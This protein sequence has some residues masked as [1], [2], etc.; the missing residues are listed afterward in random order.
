M[1]TMKLSDK[2]E[3]LDLLHELET[4][5]YR[6]RQILSGRL[7]LI[8]LRPVGGGPPWPSH[9]DTF[10]MLW[11]YLKA[12]LP[13][14]RSKVLDMGEY[15]NGIYLATEIVP[16]FQSLDQWLQSQTASFE[17][18]TV[19]VRA[20]ETIRAATPSPE[21]TR[22][23]PVKSTP[24]AQANEYGGTVVRPAPPVGAGQPALQEQAAKRVMPETASQKMEVTQIPPAL[25]EAL[26]Q[27][28]DNWLAQKRPAA[29]PVAS[30]EGL[31]GESTMIFRRPE[32]PPAISRS[33]E[34]PRQPATAAP[35]SGES[36]MLLNPSLLSPAAAQQVKQPSGIESAPLGP[37]GSGEFTRLFQTPGTGG[38][39]EP[40]PEFAKPESAFPSQAFPGEFTRMFQAPSPREATALAPPSQE[41]PVA[42]GEFTR[43][44]GSAI[45][46]V[47]A[48][49]TPAP[50]RPAGSYTQPNPAQVAPPALGTRRSF[51]PWIIVACASLA[52]LGVFLYF[53][54]RH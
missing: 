52:A 36:T 45:E 10:G 3:L 43:V 51:L 34:T 17:D 32:R 24:P 50:S 42:P 37:T 18:A 11:K 20:P 8:H 23:I 48:S 47:L 9:D 7:V 49:E 16:G 21:A 1:V 33:V 31:A 22:T 28:R 19:M 14:G 53:F 5:T 6:A 54:L 13:E 30:G 38:Q 25:T 39:A 35:D 4:K 12:T 27:A 29:A 15:E 44:F 26:T 41:A 46:S 2:Y 40:A